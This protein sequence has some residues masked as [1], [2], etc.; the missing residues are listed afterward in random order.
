MYLKRSS[1]EAVWE[2][3]AHLTH[4]SL[5]Q[6]TDFLCTVSSFPFLFFRSSLVGFIQSFQSW[7]AFRR[8]SFLASDFITGNWIVRRLWSVIHGV[9]LFLTGLI[10][11]GP[12]LALRL[13]SSHLLLLSI[14]FSPPS[15]CTWPL[16]LTSITFSYFSLGLCSRKLH[17]N[18]FSHFS[19][20]PLLL[21]DWKQ[22][23]LLALCCCVNVCLFVWRLTKRQELHWPWIPSPLLLANNASI[24]SLYTQRGE[25]WESVCT[26]ILYIHIKHIRLKLWF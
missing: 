15:L 25:E 26:H 21:S 7:R 1:L 22:L 11:T 10:N 4:P 16:P 6:T 17:C 13:Y 14:L 18:F 24:C 12:D 2:T 8:I 19:L 20:F 3:D 5:G 23:S 9:R